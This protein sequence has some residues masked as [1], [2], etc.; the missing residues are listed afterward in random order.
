MTDSPRASH[1]RG[2]L[3]LAG[4]RR[5]A[6]VLRERR[7]APAG[8]RARPC[9]LVPSSLLRTQET[10]S[11]INSDR[12]AYGRNHRALRSFTRE[13]RAMRR[14]GSCGSVGAGPRGVTLF[15]LSRTCVSCCSCSSCRLP[16]LV[17]PSSLNASP[18]SPS[19]SLSSLSALSPSLTA[20]ML[21]T[22]SGCRR[23]EDG[24]TNVTMQ[25]GDGRGGPEEPGERRAALGQRPEHG[26]GFEAHLDQVGLPERKVVVHLQLPPLAQLLLVLDELHL[27]RS[28]I[29][30]G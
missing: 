6:R 22:S 21:M 19:S 17:L 29:H 28:K 1:L 2:V 11:P 4:A 26:P 10:T 15:C 27:P 14:A 13:G 7:G 8:L 5:G 9:G 16:V 3:G 24:A 30:V 20:S 12:R 23:A 25:P 18:P